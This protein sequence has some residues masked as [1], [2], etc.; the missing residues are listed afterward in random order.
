MENACVIAAKSLGFL[1]T[2]RNRFAGRDLSKKASLNAIATA[3]DYGA[4]TIV[5]FLI[6]PLMVLFLGDIGYGIWQ[7]I[8]RSVGYISPATGRPTQ[9]LK[10]VIARSQGSTDFVQK[11]QYVGSALAIWFCAVPILLILGGLLAWGLPGWVD[12]PEPLVPAVRG[13]YMLL[14]LNII[15]VTVANL[16]KAVLAGENLGYKRM[17]LSAL[18][19]ML[20][21]ILIVLFLYLGWG[22][23]GMGLASVVTTALTGVFFLRVAKR[24]LAWFGVGRPTLRFVGRFLGLSGWFQLWNVVMRAMRTGDVVLLGIM[25]SPAVVTVYTLTRYVPETLINFITTIVFGVTPGMGRMIGDGDR[26]AAAGVRAEIMSLTW[27]LSITIGTGVLLWNAAFM[28][29]WTDQVYFAG[30]D[31][32]L[33]IV[34]MV[35]QFALIRNDANLIDL[36]LEMRTKVLL[37]LLATALSIGLGAYFLSISSNPIGALCL[38]VILGRALLTVAY[39]TLIGRSLGVPWQRQWTGIMRPVLITVLLFG[40]AYILTDELRVSSWLA[41]VNNAI[42]SGLIILAIA[43]FAGLPIPMRLRLRR[44]LQAMIR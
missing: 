29:L 18:L 11:R 10:M 26:E 3:L 32:N 34:I 1:R 37:G 25:A 9:A 43:Y 16:P 35:L 13:A 15:L 31:V 44:R 36:T 17:G 8:D 30:H 40:T 6:Q 27:L 19:V 12:T 39:P 4:R 21:G 28:A 41:L 42:L 5:G 20:N 24:E 14:V 22:L 2:V 7:V 38:G 33:L 23:V